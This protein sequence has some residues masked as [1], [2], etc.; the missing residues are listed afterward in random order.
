MDTFD[1]LD[2]FRCPGAWRG[3]AGIYMDGFHA[4]TKRALTEPAA[5][6]SSVVHTSTTLSSVGLDMQL[7]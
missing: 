5:S 3:Y 6:I 2:G 4:V 1:T 7:S